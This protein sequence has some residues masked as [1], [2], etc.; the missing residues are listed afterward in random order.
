MNPRRL[1]A[2]PL[3]DSLLA[4]SGKLNPEMFGPGIFPR[5]DPDVINTGS[6]PRWPLDAKDDHDTWRRSVYIFVK[7]S[8]LL[9]LIQLFDCPP[10]VVSGPTGA[11]PTGPPRAPAL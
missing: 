1:E 7:R 2:E 5:I 4:V 6:R 9:P 3:R 10:T 11:V 8:A